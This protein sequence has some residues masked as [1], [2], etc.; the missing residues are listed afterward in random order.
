VRRY[1]RVSGSE[2]G[3]D[4]VRAAYASVGRLAIFPL[5]DLL[6]LGSAARFNTPGRAEGNWQWRYGDHDLDCLGG[7]TTRYLREL[8]ELYD[9]TPDA[10]VAA[11][12]APAPAD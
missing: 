7:E 10:A 4:F 12:V 5:Q 9:R 3:W 1:L 6:S 2:I 8:G 11:T